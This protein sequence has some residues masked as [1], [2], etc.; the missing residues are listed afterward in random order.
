MN[1]CST[2][3]M[4]GAAPDERYNCDKV[5]MSTSF[6]VFAGGHSRL[7]NPIKLLDARPSKRYGMDV[8]GDLGF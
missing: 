4:Y 3:I 5:A 6:L 2:D 7:V 1:Q 8:S